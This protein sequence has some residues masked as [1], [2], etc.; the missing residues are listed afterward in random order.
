MATWRQHHFLAVDR[1]ATDLVEQLSLPVIGRSS[2][3]ASSICD[4]PAAFRNHWPGYSLDL[5][6]AVRRRIMPEPA[7]EFEREYDKV[8][9]SAGDVGATPQESKNM[10]ERV[11]SVEP[12]K[13]QL[14]GEAKRRGIKGRSK[15]TKQELQNALRR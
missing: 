3:A 6:S 10:A 9:K 13:D 1:L 14:L 2:S 7:K 11:G 12:T 5:V 4:G 15:M 8:Q